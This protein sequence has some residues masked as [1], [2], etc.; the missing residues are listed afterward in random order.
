MKQPKFMDF[1][2]P[3]NGTFLYALPVS[4]A[5]LF[6]EETSLVTAESPDWTV[7]ERR[8]RDRLNRL[9]LVGE[10]DVHER[11]VIPMDASLPDFA[12]EGI[13]FGAAAAMVHPAT[14]YQL[15]ASLSLA[16]PFAEALTATLE[17]PAQEARQRLSLIHI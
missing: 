4:D 10:L 1:S 13:S 5:E 17:R 6:V 7:L 2:G 8:L 11:C 16:A 3:E 9:G 12:T 15:G 14:G